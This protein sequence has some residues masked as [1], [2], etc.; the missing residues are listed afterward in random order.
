MHRVK[1]Y[2]CFRPADLCYCNLENK[3]LIE[4]NLVILMHPKEAYKQNVGTGRIAHRLCNNSKIIIGV[5]FTDN[6]E[7]N[8]LIST[9]NAYILYPGKE[10][11]SPVVFKQEVESK[12]STLIVVDGTWPCAK[13][14][15]KLS[16]NL[17][18]LPRVSFN[19]NYKSE[20]SI[21]HQPQLYCL[22]TVESIF[23]TLNEGKLA[24]NENQELLMKVFR[25]LTKF[26]IECA[27]DE[28]KRGYRRS[29]PFKKQSERPLNPKW[30]SR[31]LI[32]DK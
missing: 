22:S 3:V 7:L 18:Y 14:M 6:K 16:K 32:Y 21:K 28:T 10:A 4:F 12:I 24:L 25:D 20:F 9:T 5:D 26:Q 19:S 1:C 8:L 31:K 11:I 27:N 23:Y 15:M 17:H 13:K 2:K 29:G 30:Q